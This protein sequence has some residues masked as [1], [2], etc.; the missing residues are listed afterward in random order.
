MIRSLAPKSRSWD[1]ELLHFLKKFFQTIWRNFKKFQKNSKNHEIF[2]KKCNFPCFWQETRLQQS[3][4]S[5]VSARMQASRWGAPTLDGR[6]GSNVY[7]VYPWL[8][9]FGRGKQRL[10]GLTVDETADR[11]VAKLRDQGRWPEKACCGDSSAS[12]GGSSLIQNEVC[13]VHV[14]TS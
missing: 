1:C 4:T 8:W 10:G 7:E 9:Q 14:C 3:L 11:L 12:Q 5:T 13:L 2:T 6:R